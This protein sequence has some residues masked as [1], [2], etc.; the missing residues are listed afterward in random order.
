MIGT[1]GINFM[2]GGLYNNSVS[3]PFGT[4]GIFSYSTNPSRFSLTNFKPNTQSANNSSFSGLSS[5]DAREF[6]A[7]VKSFGSRLRFAVAGLSTTGQSVYKNVTGVSSKDD[8]LSVSVAKQAEAKRM[9][10]AKGSKDVTIKQLASTQQ[11]KGTSLNATA[12]SNVNAG[13]NQFTI[14]KDGKTYN[15]AVDVK[16]SDSSRTAQQKAADAINKQ[17]IGVT[18]TV[19]YDGKTKNSSLVLTSNETGAKNAFS[20]ADAAGG[21]IVGAFGI[22]QA[23]Q[24]AR[25]AVYTINGDERTSDKNTVDMGD[26]LTG[27]LKKVSDEPI[28]VTV[29]KDTDAIISAVSE[30]VKNFN[31]LMQ[32]AKEFGSDR[33][34]QV[35]QQRLDNLSTAYA[36]S[37]KNIGITRDKGGYLELDEK[38]LRTAFE[39]GGA[40]RNLGS[41][42]MGFLQRLSQLAKSAD[43]N[44][45]QYLSRQSRFNMNAPEDG[46][47]FYQ[48]Q[49]YSN[50]SLLFNMGV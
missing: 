8:S 20:V 13:V 40:E 4:G 31:G 9:S 49:R 39:N 21:Q 23:T 1:S 38:K 25:D 17:K 3:S 16:L 27:T 18:A 48:N 46:S 37:L 42:G 22:G 28:K 44:T 2:Y 7:A 34:A 50:I 24:E 32:T 30:M 19:E 12:L 26:G 10:D 35:L 33:G 11:N 43:T 41:D 6:M 29:T 47:F 14:A 5:W 36:P 45:S 15:F